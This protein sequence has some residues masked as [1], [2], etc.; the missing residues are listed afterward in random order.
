MERYR[1]SRILV[2]DDEEYI[3]DLVARILTVEGYSCVTAAS[4]EEA[5]KLLEDNEFHLIVSDILMPGMSGLDLLTFVKSL[6]KEVAMVMATAVS[7]RKIAIDALDMG[8]YGYIIKPFDR[9][10][11]LI[12]VAAALQRREMT[13][14]SQRYERELE[15]RVRERTREVREREE[16]VVLRLISASGFR[17][18]ETGAHIRRIGLYSFEMAQSLGWPRELSER[19]RLAAPMHDVGKIGIPDEI[20]RKPGKFT[21]EEFEIMKKHTEIGARILNGSEVPLLQMA[22][23]VAYGHHERYDGSGYPRGLAADEIPESCLI[24]AVVDVYDALVHDRVYRPA[25]SEQEALEIMTAGDGEHF[26]DRIFD[27]FRDLLPTMRRIAQ[28]VRDDEPDYSLLPHLAT[29]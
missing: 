3:R 10:E 29:Q 28:D 15:E 21:S 1:S 6:Y 18:D 22:K 11:L 4:G 20:L 27:C 26:G 24:V 2:V 13:L 19:L 12:S 14:L 17:D 16:E 9:N 25:L 23:E 7:D 5:V 8:A